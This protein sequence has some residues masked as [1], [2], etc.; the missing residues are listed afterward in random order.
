MLLQFAASEDPAETEAACKAVLLRGGTVELPPRLLAI[1]EPALTNETAPDWFPAW[2]SGTRAL[3][4]YR[5]GDS[6]AAVSWSRKS[7]ELA[8]NRPEPE[9]SRIS[10]LALAVE[11]MAR[12]QLGQT[13]ESRKAFEA[14]TALIP[15]ELRTIVSGTADQEMIA[16]ADTI[17]WDWLIAELL[18]REAE[19][20]IIE[21][22]AA[23]GK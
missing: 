13:E 11:A 22:L 20:L 9:Q 14:A 2:G 7:V 10:A 18:R 1:F 12:Q 15:A 16:A 17:H 5:A 3:V 19:E 23:P 8:M 6:K 4:A 21:K